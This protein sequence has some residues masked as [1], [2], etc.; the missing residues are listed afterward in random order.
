MC[1]VIVAVSSRS[2]NDSNL[3]TWRWPVRPKHVV[4]IKKND[5]WAV[6]EVARRRHKSKTQS[7]IYAVQQDVAMWYVFLSV[8]Q[9]VETETLGT[10]AAVSQ[11][12]S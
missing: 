9:N 12:P 7:Q 11:K 3:Y 2:L 8:P 1:N 10:K 5:E 6:T 4:P